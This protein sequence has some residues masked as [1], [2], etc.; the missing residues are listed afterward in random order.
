MKIIYSDGSIANMPA[1]QLGPSVARIEQGPIA[2]ERV[3]KQ[4]ERIEDLKKDL[5]NLTKAAKDII[6]WIV[7]APGE[8]AHIFT[9]F[10]VV[11]RLATLV[12]KYE[13]I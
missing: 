3:E 2:L 7:P 11:A 9:E 12:K 5:E 8:A 1:V 4:Q 13:S 6:K 10:P